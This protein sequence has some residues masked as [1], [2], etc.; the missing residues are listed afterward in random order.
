MLETGYLRIPGSRPHKLSPKK[1]KKLREQS[2]DNR[3]HLGKIPEYNA[4]AD[5]HLQKFLPSRKKKIILGVGRI[6]KFKESSNKNL[7]KSTSSNMIPKNQVV[8]TQIIKKLKENLNVYWEQKGIPDE[9]RQI[10]LQ[11]VEKL[12]AKKQ[13]SVLVK[14]MDLYKHDRNPNQLVLRAIKARENSLFELKD[15]ADTISNPTSIIKQNSVESLI[16]LRMLSLHVVECIQAWRKY[17]HDLDPELIPD[18][19]R[20]TWEGQNYL[21]KMFSD[22][23][24]LRNSKMAQFIDFTYNDPFFVYCSQQ[25][26]K[27]ELPLPSYLLKRIKESEKVL[28]SEGLVLREIPKKVN[29]TQELKVSKSKILENIQN[30]EIVFEP[31]GNN[32]ENDII[33]YSADVPML[34]QNSMGKCSVVF[35][36]ALSMR[37]PAFFWAKV[38]NVKVGLISLNLDNQK[39]VQN[40]IL[41]SHISALNLEIFEKM[42]EMIIKY[43]WSS[44]SCNEIRV[45]IIAKINEQG[46]YECEAGIKSIFDSHGFRW[47]QMIYAINEI[48]V[49]ILGLRRTD[50]L[51]TTQNFSIFSD[52]LTISYVCG[53]QK[54]INTLTTPKNFISAIGLACAY[55]PYNSSSFGLFSKILTKMTGIPPAFRYRKDSNLASASR[56]LNTFQINLSELD[57]FQ[58]TSV[59]YS[60]LGISWEKFLPVIYNSKKLTK[61]L[62]QVNIMKSENEIVYVLPTEDP[63]YNVF[64]I[65]N[66]DGRVLGKFEQTQNVLRQMEK[67]GVE[68]EIWLPDFE[69]ERSAFDDGFEERI[70][71]KVATAMHPAGGYIEYPTEGSVVIGNR[72]IIGVIHQKL[73]EDLELPLYVFEV[74]PEDII[75]IS[76]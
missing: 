1:D 66:E 18:N 76:N 71:F 55:R 31:A 47:K 45:G 22:S 72:F 73:D 69:V 35:S 12:N 17:L 44:Y 24:F 52:S 16:N 11:V 19:L 34:I 21:K 74:M 41:I 28:E 46:K 67:V 42:T 68:S 8:K 57:P 54:S 48:P 25:V 33:E 59:A 62:T 6:R 30:E 43:L 29:K 56:D 60:S 40:R 3:F 65:P 27:I 5:I 70:K 50:T 36:T 75:K 7:L 13:S 4:V 39:S 20:F 38:K 63:A 26:G 58:E 9:F 15:F 32:I 53:I 2:W 10:F 49:Q 51:A 64:V 61:I 23:E 14:E 37:F